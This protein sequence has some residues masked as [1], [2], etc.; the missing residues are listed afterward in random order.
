MVLQKV[1]SVLALSATLFTGAL[2]E[3][4]PHR[5]IDNSLF[6]ANREYPLSKDYI[7][8]TVELA[9]KGSART[10]QAE[11]A[12]ALEAMFAAA[13]EEDKINL[14]TV[15]GYRS[16][17]KQKEVYDSKLKKVNGNEDKANEYVAPPGTSEHQLAMTMDVGE[18]DVNTTLTESFARTKGGKW[19]AANAHRFG[20][21]IHF[22]EGWEEITGYSYE[23]WHVRYVGVDHATYMYEQNIPLE[24][25]VNS[26]RMERMLYLLENCGSP[27][28]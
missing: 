7:P 14:V 20:F 24:L 26:F 16:Y 18:K 21:I 11:S 1:M 13:K 2:Y 9:T 17:A 5:D 3:T 25:Y 19:L 27:K 28:G 10:M 4:T 6:L 22:Q 8:I 23:P 15:S 12:R